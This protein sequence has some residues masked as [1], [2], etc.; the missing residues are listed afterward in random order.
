MD[1]T[2]FVF[3]NA[4]EGFSCNTGTGINRV[5]VRDFNI[6]KAGT[7]DTNTNTG[8][9]LSNVS[10]SKFS[11]IKIMYFQHGVYMRRTYPGGGFL[12]CYFD[13]FDHIHTMG[14]QHGIT[15][16]DNGGTVN[17][18][19]FRNCMAEYNGQRIDGYGL[20]LDG[21]GHTV[22]NFYG[23]LPNHIAALRLGPAALNCTLTDIYGESPALDIVLKDDTGAGRNNVIINV[24]SDGGPIVVSRTNPA[25]NAV[26]INAASSTNVV[27]FRAAVVNK[28]S[29]ANVGT[30]AY[31]YMDF[32]VTGIAYDDVAVVMPPAAWPPGLIRSAPIVSAG[33][34]RMP[35]FN[36]TGGTLPPPVGDYRVVWQDLT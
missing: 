9:M 18:C 21:V 6:E 31:D 27:P 32:V 3:D 11:R 4:V 28:A 12:A 34:V 30:L 13:D 17:D 8:L 25:S 1:V 23:G 24:H 14:C 10:Y 7:W 16:A 2:R 33:S 36:G 35:Y 15:V 29:T 20:N 5:Q 22:S 26:Y 19:S